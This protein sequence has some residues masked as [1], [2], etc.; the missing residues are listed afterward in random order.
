MID[1]RRILA[2]LAAVIAPTLA[3]A[4][5]WS[6]L[7]SRVVEHELPNGM[8]FLILERHEAPLVSFV[9]SVNAGSVNEVTNKTGI[10]HLL[11][12][13]AFKGTK[14]IGTTDYNAESKALAELDASYEA[15]IKAKDRGADSSALAPLYAVFRADLKK[16]SSYSRGGEFSEIY[17][18]NGGT[19]LNAGTSYDHTTY[20]VTLPSNRFELWAAMESERLTNPIFRDFYEE[21]DVIKE[22]RRMRVDNTPSGLFYEDL[23]SVQYKTVP[24]GQPIVGHASDIAHL[25]RA[26]VQDFYNK[27]YVPQEMTAAIVGDVN[28]GDI[29][30]VIDA[31]FSRIPAKHDSP[32]VISREPEQ[33]DVRRLEMKLP[34]VSTYVYVEFQTVSKA[35]KDELVL[36]LL[37][38]VLGDGRTSRLYRSLV[39]ERKLASYVGASNSS[40]KYVGS[41]SVRAGGLDG[42]TAAELEKAILEELGKL[43]EK[44]VTQDELDAAR[45]R[46]QVGQFSRFSSNMGMAYTLAI[47]DQEPGGWRAR[48]RL[49]TAL[50]EITT[51]DLA[52]AASEYFKPDCRTVGSMEVNND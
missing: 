18:R 6:D 39:E 26:D 44:P 37:G 47:G 49:K 29:I 14:K 17:E 36:D 50:S 10:A 20:I 5:T 35:D 30:P 28:A 21:R 9:I 34:N 24:Y 48:F 31:Y 3:G 32:V 15:Y 41:F 52:R 22:E 7:E 13:L 33:K 8:R 25:E 51:D 12:H 43:S 40:F 42:V 46:W 45:A 1:I 19:G 11:E 38:R 2:I 23:N 4:D 16:A 27:Y